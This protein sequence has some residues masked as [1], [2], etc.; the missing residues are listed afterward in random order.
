ML[1]LSRCGLEEDLD[2]VLHE[3]L[4]RY[5]PNAEG[6]VVRYL[7]EAKNNHMVELARNLTTED[8]KSIYEHYNFACLKEVM[9]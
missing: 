7:Q 3:Q 8:C 2:E 1:Y 9:E 6:E 4:V 5:L